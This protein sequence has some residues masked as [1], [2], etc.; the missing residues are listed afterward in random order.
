MSR[1]GPSAQG[2]LAWTVTFASGSGGLPTLEPD[3]ASLV[4]TGATVRVSTLANGIAPLRG[5]LSLVVSGVDGEVRV[6]GPVKLR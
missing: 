5:M 6:A 3:V 1:T 2:E 4:G